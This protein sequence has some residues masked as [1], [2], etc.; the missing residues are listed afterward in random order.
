MERAQHRPRRQRRPIQPLIEGLER[1][2]D[3]VAQAIGRHRLHPPIMHAPP[4][5]RMTWIATPARPPPPAHLLPGPP[6]GAL[7]ASRTALRDTRSFLPLSANRLSAARSSAGTR[8]AG[9]TWAVWARGCHRRL[10]LAASA[11]YDLYS[12]GMIIRQSISP[13]F[14]TGDILLLLECQ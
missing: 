7:S 5:A 1:C 3:D 2:V 10:L 12:S 13:I 4:A 6:S 11:P 14:I 9:H 8:R